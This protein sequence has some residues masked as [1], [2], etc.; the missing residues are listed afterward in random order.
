M[1]EGAVAEPSI[2]QETAPKV[3][4]SAE[5]QTTEIRFTAIGTLNKKINQAE[6]VAEDKRSEGQRQLA[7]LKLLGNAREGSFATKEEP[8]GIDLQKAQ[9]PLEVTVDGNTCRVTHIQS[10]SENSF[11][12][13][14]A[15]DAPD[16]SGSRYETYDTPRAD[17]VNA[18]LIAES[19]AI[20]GEF[21]GDAKTAIELYIKSLRGE[22]ITQDMD[23]E[24]IQR[25]IEQVAADSGMLT[26]NDLKGFVERVMPE[27]LA[28]NGKQLTAE[29]RQ[30]NEARQKAIDLLDGRAIADPQTVMDTLSAIG[31]GPEQ[32]QAEAANLQTEITTLEAKKDKTP[33]EMDALAK[34]KVKADIIGQFSE[35]MNGCFEAALGGQLGSEQSKAVIAAFKT[36]NM[37]AVIDA[38]MDMEDAIAAGLS[39]DQKRRRREQLKKDMQ[40]I[41]IGSGV[42]ALG[43]LFKVLKQGFSYSVSGR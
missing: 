8:E 12:C 6:S 38:A 1:P 26:A 13:A 37:T 9:H 35:N 20:L 27:Q 17:L 15:I 29:Q 19:G 43:L 33:E 41:G 40:E 25:V 4:R 21:D 11:R 34:L 22:D 30:H 7:S 14:V 23:A 16:G 3:E 18:Q 31:Y 39:E 32:I 2:Q 42:M 36:G 28:E 10:A 5:R 24:Q